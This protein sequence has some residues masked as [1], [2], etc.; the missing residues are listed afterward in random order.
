MCGGSGGRGERGLERD[1]K[2]GVGGRWGERK[3][4]KLQ[5]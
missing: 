3:N 1:W 5:T 4:V 2:D